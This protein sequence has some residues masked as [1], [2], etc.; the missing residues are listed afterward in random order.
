MARRT[1]VFQTNPDGSYKQPLEMI[2]KHKRK[3][4]FCG[5]RTDK[6]AH[7]IIDDIEPYQSTID[8]SVIGSR[9]K[10]RAHLKQHG[11]VEVGCDTPKDAQ[12]YFEPKKLSRKE[13]I[14]DV[15][16]VYDKLASRG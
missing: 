16:N 13:R 2:E 7:N 14:E 15:K 12:K 5:E 6:R 1:Y 9:S 3:Y 10:H 8:G 11:C 4:P